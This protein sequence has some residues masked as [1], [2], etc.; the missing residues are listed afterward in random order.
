MFN[1]RAGIRRRS[2]LAQRER[3]QRRLT[4]RLENDGVA[5]REGRRDLPHRQQQRKIPRHDRRDD[6]DGLTQRVDEGVALDRD[7]L[8]ADLVRPAA[9]YWR[10]SAAI[11]ISM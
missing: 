6:A 11:G 4:G 7:R 3:G 10:H 8:A 1:T 9:K 5:H 2:Q